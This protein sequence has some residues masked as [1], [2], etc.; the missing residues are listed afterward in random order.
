MTMTG[1]TDR[2]VTERLAEWIVKAGPADVPPVGVE[3]VRDRVIDSLGVMCAGMAEPTGRLIRQWVQAQGGTPDC[4]V[5]AAGFRTTAPLATLANATAGHALEF[6]D[7]ATFG[8]HYASPLTAAALAVGEKLGSSGRDVILAWLVGWEVIAQ[9][10]KPCASPTGNDL[11]N[12]GWFNQGFQPV[13]G[14]AALAAKL[15]GFDVRQTRMALGNAAGAMGGLLKNRGSDT[16]SFQA[17]SAAMHGVMAAEL[18]DLGFTAN[19]DVIDGE[20]G[21]ARLLGLDNGDPEKV[22]DG[23]GSWDMATKG[24]TI[25]LHACCGAGHWAMDALQHILRRHPFTPDQVEAI[26][27]EIDAFLLPMVPYHAPTTGLEAK[28]SLEYDLATIV[29][30]GRGGLHQY[31]D[32]AVRRPEAQ[33]L[34][35]RVAYH[36]VDEVRRPQSRVVVTLKDGTTLEETANRS[37]GSPADPLS[38]AEVVAKFDECAEALVPEARRRLLVDLCRRLDAL[39]NVRELTE[40]VRTTG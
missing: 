6:D 37:H 19:E 12:R 21:V 2:S 3:R 38:D 28:Y 1:A 13:L 24:S 32:A 16:K 30:D 25:R 33:A 35:A 20:F 14:V 40:V 11:L 27:V 10:S 29:L 7:I 22:L 26:D 34:M 8:G 17:G 4:T 31:H 23:L 5:V 9:T 36:P 39:D 15:M 18:V